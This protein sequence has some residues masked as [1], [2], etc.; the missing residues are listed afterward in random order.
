MYVKHPNKHNNQQFNVNAILKEKKKKRFQPM[1]N[2]LYVCMYVLY[3]F[4]I[5]IWLEIVLIELIEYKGI[6]KD[7]SLEL[8]FFPSGTSF[9]N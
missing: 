8:K 1:L 3:V 5:L 6:V 9:T 7:V 2:Y 4:F